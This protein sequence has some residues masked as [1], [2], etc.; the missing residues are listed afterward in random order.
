VTD[1]VLLTA[2]RN[3]VE[4]CIDLAVEYDLG[5]EVM[6]FAYPDILD[7]NW[8]QTLATYRNMLRRIAGPITLHGPFMDMVGGSP[9]ERINQVCFQRYQHAIHIASELDAELIVLHANFIGSLHN[10]EYRK[11]WHQRNVDFWGSLAEY[12]DGHEITVTLENMWEF[13]PGIIRDLLRD[14]DHPRMKACLDIGHA[15]VFGDPEYSLQDW[16]NAM[17]PWLIHTH[18]NN[19]N[20]QLDEHHGFDWEHGVLDYERILKR[21]RALKHQ[22]NIVLEMYQVEDMRQS[23]SYLEIGQSDP[24]IAT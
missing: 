24:T 2:D 14:L 22:P 4:D 17:E 3:N 6:A 18:M 7:G 15:Y 23:L 21:V 16:L 9:D 13:E 1:R 20:G 12:A 8:Q 10:S 5:I 19:N 11:G